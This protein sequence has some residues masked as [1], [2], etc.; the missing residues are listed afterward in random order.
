MFE[1]IDNCQVCTCVIRAGVEKFVYFIVGATEAIR[2]L[3]SSLKISVC[4]NS[5]V[6]HTQY[7]PGLSV[8]DRG[9]SNFEG[10]QAQARSRCGSG[11]YTRD[12]YVFINAHTDY[13]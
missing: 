7:S 13:Q 4:F 9:M 3:D 2:R 6:A 8:E 1:D 5:G 10:F 11:I 12:R